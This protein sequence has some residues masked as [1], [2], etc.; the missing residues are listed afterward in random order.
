MAQGAPDKVGVLS[1]RRCQG[2]GEERTNTE[3]LGSP[4]EPPTAGNHGEIKAR[5]NRFVETFRG[6]MMEVHVESRLWL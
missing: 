4:E 6:A 1:G 5:K 3:R 2:L